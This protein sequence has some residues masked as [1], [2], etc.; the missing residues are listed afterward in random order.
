MQYDKDQYETKKHREM[1]D[2]ICDECDSHCQ[3]RKRDIRISISRNQERLFCSKEC[4]AKHSR[5]EERN[6][7]AGKCKNC[8][9]ESVYPNLF[10]SSSCSA[11]Y[12]N[13]F[14]IKRGKT[15]SCHGC[16]AN[17]YKYPNQLRDN[18]SGL[19][20]CSRDC[21]DKFKVNKAARQNRDIV[22][23]QCSANFQRYSTQKGKHGKEFCSRSCRM[24]YFNIHHKINEGS[25]LSVSYPEEYLNVKLTT[26]FKDLVIS[27][28][29]RT[30]LECGY[31]M[32]FFFPDLKFAIEVNGPIHY[33]PIFGGVRLDAVQA[34]DSTKY[35]EMNH[36]GISFLIIDVSQSI[37]KKKMAMYLDGLFV[38]KIQPIIESKLRR[39]DSN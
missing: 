10:C 25:G 17:C 2:C 23:S 5:S 7:H 34:K 27:R 30:F 31:E 36:K 6:N 4:S 15:V 11:I 14:K 12:T 8:E 26:E 37:S 22:C 9:K 1:I 13:Q 3:R 16:G 24:K 19:H 35:A 39:L 28:N 32:D 38:E 33:M 18:I 20:F 21:S 29:N